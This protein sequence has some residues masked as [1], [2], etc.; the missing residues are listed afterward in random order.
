MKYAEIDHLNVDNGKI[1]F[2][3][4]IDGLQFD[5]NVISKRSKCHHFVIFLIKI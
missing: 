2:V 5:F 3:N 1:A 4:N